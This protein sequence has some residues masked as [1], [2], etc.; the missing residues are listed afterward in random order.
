MYLF[1]QDK[2]PIYVQKTSCTCHGTA[3]L[4][5]SDLLANT[6]RLMSIEKAS[7]YYSPGG[8]ALYTAFCFSWSARS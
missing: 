6:V 2:I 1:V 8:E 7:F 3:G 4:S 5:S